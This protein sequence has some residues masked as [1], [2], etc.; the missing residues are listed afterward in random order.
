MALQLL[1]TPVEVNLKSVP[2]L[3]KHLRRRRAELWQRSHSQPSW[4]KRGQSAPRQTLLR[5]PSEIRCTRAKPQEWRFGQVSPVL[6]VHAVRQTK[7]EPSFNW[8]L[9]EGAHSELHDFKDDYN[10]W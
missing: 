2:S 8:F 6:R 10:K 1:Q 4:R 3:R 5:K 9:L 7:S